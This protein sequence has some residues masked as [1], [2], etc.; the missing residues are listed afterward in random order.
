MKQ[1]IDGK[2][3][4][5]TTTTTKKQKHR[6]DNTTN[7]SHIMCAKSNQD[8]QLN[9][10]IAIKFK[11]PLPEIEI[12]IEICNKIKGDFTKIQHTHTKAA[13]VGARTN[14]KHLSDYQI[15]EQFVQRQTKKRR[16]TIEWISAMHASSNS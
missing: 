6:K 16:K 3:Q 13:M 12:E 10:S 4:N 11:R 7:C 15:S 9:F 1:N 5:Q 14:T 2:W 8:K